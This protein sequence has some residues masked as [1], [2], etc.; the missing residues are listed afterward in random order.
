MNKLPGLKKSF[1]NAKIVWLTTFNKEGDEI[2]RQMT[3]YNEDPYSEMWFP[4]WTE[5]RKVRH[6]QNNPK[7]YITFPSEEENKFFR[8]QGKTRIADEKTT[9]EKWKWWYLT[10]IP[11]DGSKYGLTGTHGW[12]SRTILL[13]NPEIALKMDKV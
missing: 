5:T 11:G 8:I 7:S 12:D 10:W 6:I 2:D 4:T 13:F 9:Y 3:N 1:E